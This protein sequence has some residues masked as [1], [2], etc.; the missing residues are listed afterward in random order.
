MREQEAGEVGVHALVTADELVGEGQ[1]RH[2]AALL[3]PEDSSEGAR[4]EDTLDGSK[5]D[6]ALGESRPVV[7]NPLKC[8]FSLLLDARNGLNGVEK[9]LALCGIFDVSVDQERVGL[10]VDIF[11]KRK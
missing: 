9:E 3:Q 11:P 2:K 8:P 1:A 6:E 7:R 10:R 5:S 4:E